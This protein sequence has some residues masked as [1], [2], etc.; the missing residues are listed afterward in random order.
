MA[1][2]RASLPRSPPPFNPLDPGSQPDGPKRADRKPAG[3]PGIGEWARLSRWLTL[4]HFADRG[5]QLSGST[6]NERVADHDLYV[7]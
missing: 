2:I 1:C 5:P 3:Q 6:S 4:R 7:N